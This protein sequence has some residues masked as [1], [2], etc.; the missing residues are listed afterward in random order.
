ME[1]LLGRVLT[2][3][4]TNAGSLT[5]HLVLAFSV[6]GSLFTALPLLAGG[7]GSRAR[8]MVLGLGLLLLL[9]VGNFV[10][11]GWAWQGALSEESFLP[12][13]DRSVTLLGLLLIVWMWAFPKQSRGA[14]AGTFL[15]LLLTIA[16]IAMGAVWWSSQA[17][18]GPL[19]FNGS[20]VDTGAEILALTLIALGTLCLLLSRPASWGFGLC[21]L[22]L[23]F[24]GHLVHL[25][26]PPAGGDYAGAV[27][28]A[29]MA[30]YPLL[31]FLPYRFLISP[32]PGLASA[33]DV[34]RAVAET[35]PKLL[36][37]F[38]ALSTETDPDRVC[39]AVAAAISRLMG[40][41]LCLFVQTVETEGQ[42][43]LQCGYNLNR[44]QQ[45][46]PLPVERFD[47][48]G[49]A[50]A[51]SHGRSLRLP[52]NSAEN[53]VGDIPVLLGL[54]QCGHLLAVP[55]TR[56]E[57]R[58]SLGIVLLSPYSNR[59]WTAED[60]VTL[61]EIA[62]AVAYFLQRNSQLAG[63]ETEVTESKTALQALQ[64]QFV[65][66]Q[67]E[68]ESLAGRL[69]ALQQTADE[70]HL[71]LESL[72]A[73]LAEYE[74]VKETLAQL[75]AENEKLR[76][77]MPQIE[78]QMG[79]ELRLALQEVALLRGALAEADHKIQMLQ[80]GAAGRPI[81]SAKLEE[82][83]EVAQ[84]LRQPLA[85]TIG[86][87]ELL[88]SESLGLL[89]EP[90]KKSLEKIRAAAE[91]LNSLVD[92]LLRLIRSQN[93]QI[94]ISK[95]PVEI[96]LVLTDAVSEVRPDLDEKRISLRVEI[97]ERLPTVYADAA[98]L[99]K[100]IHSLLQ[101]AGQNTPEG[102]IVWLRAKVES[103]E[104]QEDFLLVQVADNGPGIPQEERARLFSQARVRLAEGVGAEELD[105]AMVRVI[106][107]EHGGRI[108]VDSDPGHAT[109][110]SVLLPLEGSGRPDNNGRSAGFSLGAPV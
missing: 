74:E 46:A 101:T 61:T 99:R 105:L 54:K 86:Y 22:L 49:L 95:E 102:G 50:A 34:S 2:L 36:S 19:A 52:A 40:A 58:K 68:K 89:I 70:E 13:A 100:V 109:I 26:F 33:G 32:E 73:M 103:R 23:S 80:Q 87:V 11:A 31:L 57:A 20:L 39:Q 107:E 7:M 24:I 56:S 6:F 64:E 15:L 84:E 8:R 9:R 96:R 4:S 25:L 29:Q 35:D 59:P 76:Q 71:Q 104:A 14:D 106:V 90:Q 27:R 108:W 69:S 77:S 66:V 12:L 17:G 98:A 55:V 45:V 72:A 63:L 85:S 53:E 94:F 62:R 88:L 97:P 30:S 28:L 16:A 47:A 38:L 5:Y 110:F 18:A 78:E 3:L 91:R 93:V 48:I 44:E 60:Q 37:T 1:S 21:M 65:Q 10:L 43:S 51:L 82:M 83:A 92:E 41:D 75:Q 67:Q 79:G 42:L 81:S